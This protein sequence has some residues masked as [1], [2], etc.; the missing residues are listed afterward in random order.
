MVARAEAER[1]LAE[2]RQR[3]DRL[4]EQV[5]A[6]SV[7]VVRT[8]K[9]AEAV[10]G[11]AERAEADRDAE[12]DRAGRRPGR[13]R[14]SWSRVWRSKG[15]RPNRPTCGHRKLRRR[16]AWPRRRPR[17]C[18]RPRPSGRRGGVW[19]GSGRRGGGVARRPPPSWVPCL[20]AVAFFFDCLP[21][22]PAH[23]DGIV[24][25]R[26][27]R[28]ACGERR[29]FRVPLSSPQREET[30][31]PATSPRRMPRAR[32]SVRGTGR[33][34]KPEQLARRCCTSKAMARFDR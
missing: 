17:R 27:R 32:K 23:I 1:A 11:R 12:R 4:N 14:R 25:A 22:E 30:S 21:A 19:R 7:E 26:S 9:Q 33:G 29:T 6:P 13:G 31:V 15:R 5:E 2:E 10:V 20:R 8:K 24:P 18:G 34:C 28:R 3:A 16:C